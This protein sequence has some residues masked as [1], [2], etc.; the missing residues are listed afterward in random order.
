[1]ASASFFRPPV[2]TSA[3]CTLP[4]SPGH[5]IAG[6]NGKRLLKNLLYEVANESV[7][8]NANCNV[9]GKHNVCCADSRFDCGA[10]PFN[11]H[12]PG[13]TACSWPLT[14][15]SSRLSDITNP[16][17]C[18]WAAFVWSDNSSIPS[19]GTSSCTAQI[20]TSIVPDLVAALIVFRPSTCIATRKTHSMFHTFQSSAGQ[21]TP[22]GEGEFAG[23][24][25][26]S[27]GSRRIS[28]SNACVECRRRK[29]R[30]DGTQPCGQCVWYQHPEVSIS[31]ICP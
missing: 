10:E 25:T 30:C 13:S 14:S 2:P 15:L 16:I 21:R 7:Q 27:T 9:S 23:K 8:S 18:P 29:I 26:R 4:A 22:A 31:F 5:L 28:T 19:H 11:V 1:M 24:P 17:L 20:P 12:T 3:C 6:A